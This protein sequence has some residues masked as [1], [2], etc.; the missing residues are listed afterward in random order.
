MHIQCRLNNEVVQMIQIDA[1]EDPK[2]LKYFEK[3]F[4][5]KNKEISFEQKTLIVGDYA[6]PEKGNMI[7]E[8]KTIEDFIGSY[9]S[10]HMASQC[11]N[12]EANYSE[13]YL[14]ISGKRDKLF[15]KKDLPIGIQNCKAFSYM[16]MKLHLLKSFPQLRIVEFENDSQLA[17][18]V[19]ELFT[20]EGSKR[21]DDIVRRVVDKDD[22]LL[23]Q[24]AVI[25]GVGIKRAKSI[26]AKY[27]PKEL[28][29]VDEKELLGIEGIGKKYAKKIK[30]IF[31]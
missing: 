19:V 5:D 9:Q 20:Y 22:I 6:C 23:S 27:T 18:G 1:R 16:K 14:F 24:I 12:M 21:I 30:E 25:P 29:S 7:V 15:F 4:L 10:G 13:N 17:E 2:M 3:M 28:Y 8:R 26:K 11:G 31:C